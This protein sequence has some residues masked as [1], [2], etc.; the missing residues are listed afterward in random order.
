MR[1][2]STAGNSRAVE[3]DTVGNTF[4]VAS[5]RGSSVVARLADDGV[6]NDLSGDEYGTFRSLIWINQICAGNR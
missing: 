6:Q 5:F 1:Q 2:Q 4:P 3:F